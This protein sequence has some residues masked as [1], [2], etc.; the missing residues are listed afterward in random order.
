MPSN[1]EDFDR[2]DERRATNNNDVPSLMLSNLFELL[3][4]IRLAWKLRHCNVP[5]IDYNN[6]ILIT[7]NEYIETMEAKVVWKEA[8]Q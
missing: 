4:I 3:C 8:V 7:S 5:F 2:V 1:L 6:S